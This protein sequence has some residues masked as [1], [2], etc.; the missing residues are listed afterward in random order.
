[1]IRI[2]AVAWGNKMFKIGE[3]SKLAQVSGHLL[4]H[5]DDIGLLRPAA[6]DE[7]N[8]YRYYSATQLPRLNQI[9][10][11]R[12]MDLSLEQIQNMLDGSVT[13]EEI[14]HMFTLKKAQLEQAIREDGQKLQS[15]EARLQRIDEADPAEQNQE[16]DMVV[17]SIPEM[18]IVGLRDSFHDFAAAK[19]CIGEMKHALD[20]A[21]YE[22]GH[23]V[24]ILHNE[25]MQETGHELELGFIVDSAVDPL[26]IT[27]GR[28]AKTRVLPAVDQMVTAVR[29]GIPSSAHVCRNDVALWIESNNYKISGP[30]REVF[31][32]PPFPGQEEK[33][34]T[35]IQYPIV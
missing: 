3:F 4:R 32:V 23:L 6:V 28:V 20:A 24:A 13:A 18:T 26:E 1:M 5:Y 29:V 19:R 14:R 11:L 22:V 21:K 10:A 35:E 16:F 33:T 27:P 31:L 8:G 25:T 15:I 17:K 34:V 7:Q 9:L 2:L 12:A 30:G